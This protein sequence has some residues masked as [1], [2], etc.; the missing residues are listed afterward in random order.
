MC[1]GSKGGSFVVMC[2][3][4]GY[5]CKPAPMVLKDAQTPLGL[6]KKALEKETSSASSVVYIPLLSVQT[7]ETQY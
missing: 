7:G 1:T 4:G 6:A 3:V 5:F 2:K